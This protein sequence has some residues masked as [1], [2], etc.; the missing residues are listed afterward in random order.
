MPSL[1]VLVKIA[2]VL[3]VS[4]S[5]LVRDVP[6][7][8]ERPYHLVRNTDVAATE[9]ESAPGFEYLALMDSVWKQ[10][11]FQAFLVTLQPDAARE[12]VTT[13]GHEFIHMLTGSMTLLLGD[14]AIPLYTGDSI[15]FDGRI[16][17]VP[18]NA[19]GLKTRFL[20]VYLIDGSVKD[21]N[22]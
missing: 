10:G 6:T 5:H 15:F 22:T 3:N 13:D 4:L 20:V 9:R 12:C 14:E 8:E 19:S 2:R 7:H 21:N 17:H 1:P 11:S 16:P 18:K